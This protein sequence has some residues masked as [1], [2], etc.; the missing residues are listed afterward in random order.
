VQSLREHEEADRLTLGDKLQAVTLR[1]NR[2][3]VE[4]RAAEAEAAAL[5]K[6]VQDS[7][8]HREAEAA[9][10]QA[11]L[12]KEWEAGRAEAARL[13]QELRDAE[14][15]SGES[16]QRFAMELS[17]LSHRLEEASQG[18]KQSEAQAAETLACLE[19]AAAEGASELSQSCEALQVSRD[20]C[21]EAEGR[22]LHLETTLRD[23]TEK[24]TA[25]VVRLE[26]AVSQAE[27]DKQAALGESSQSHRELQASLDAARQNVI[28]RRTEI[29]ILQEQ[30]AEQRAVVATSQQA[31][32]SDRAAMATLTI[33]VEE[34][35]QQRERHL[36][37][38]ESHA[39]ASA[40]ARRRE[41]QLL[42]E[43]CEEVACRREQEQ[44]A[45]TLEKR[46]AQQQEQ[47]DALER[48]HE[49]LV[50]ASEARAESSMLALSNQN[51]DHQARVTSLSGELEEAVRSAAE[52]AS[53]LQAE[54][55]AR[56]SKEAA[57]Q[58][59]H[60]NSLRDLVL[61][62]DALDAE[63]QAAA[64]ARTEA[65][66]EVRNV[67]EAMEVSSGTLRA[68]LS[69]SAAAMAKTRAEVVSQTEATD[70]A[71]SEL[72][73]YRASATASKDELATVACAKK[74]DNARIAELCSELAAAR[75]R[76]QK[77]LC[78]GIGAKLELS[79][80][81]EPC[82][83]EHDDQLANLVD[84]LRAAEAKRK[85]AAASA[86]NE[87]SR[88]AAEMEA[89]AASAQTAHM[90]MQA[91]RAAVTDHVAG[92]ETKIAKARVEN[93]A[94]RAAADQDRR[95]SQ[96]KFEELRS[97]ASKHLKEL[98]GKLA[99]ANKA[100]SS[101]R[102]ENQRLGHEVHKSEAA[103]TASLQRI[104][105][106]HVELSSRSI[107]VAAARK[108]GARKTADSKPRRVDGD[109]SSAKRS[110]VAD[111]TKPAID[112]V[113]PKSTSCGEHHKPGVCLETAGD[114]PELCTLPLQE[115]PQE[116]PC[117]S[118]VS[119]DSSTS[120]VLPSPLTNVHSD[121]ISPPDSESES[122]QPS[123]RGRR[124]PCAGVADCARS[125]GSASVGL[126]SGR[127][128][129]RWSQNETQLLLRGV[130]DLGVGRWKAIQQ[131]FSMLRTNVQLK[132][133]YRNVVKQRPG[134]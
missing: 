28:A 105:Q 58:S 125:V 108:G 121:D 31:T 53:Q 22:V 80:G 112:K 84:Q 27:A 40:Q 44:A 65:C 2:C 42:T 106:L 48:V 66:E 61:L 122:D 120:E 71:L 89:H 82:S 132:D 11:D 118:Q 26:K 4:L 8:Q 101:M 49:T 74:A 116:V 109:G 68:E 41:E 134:A 75:Q 1:E 73:E 6:Q 62:R 54:R 55:L 94:L 47:H 30:L 56:T 86:E 36:Q 35:R 76:E 39:D 133:R 131:E 32:M 124:D 34:F 20:K 9:A 37:Q 64:R 24:H 93:S 45:R 99:Q 77:M 70:A 38:T 128:R 114:S 51:Q 87:R 102:A 104:Q 92:L 29:E 78:E 17:Q 43:F 18:W 119:P 25:A 46:V 117:S 107:E 98:R 23:S 88:C 91:F 50:E 59:E 96:R 123:S 79:G 15:A 103:A 16:K 67:T 127:A 5:A 111:S 90:E 115:S 7:Q 85:D 52:S 13:E 63:K 19:K 130:Q 69:D 81:P 21:R 110:K 33:E 113:S 10:A 60:Q 100:H 57:F 83:G 95:A 97:T 129:G 12:H 14:Q 126:A 3:R 72:V